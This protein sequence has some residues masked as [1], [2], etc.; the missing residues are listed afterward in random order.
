M[1]Q[2]R[3]S[4]RSV[5][6]RLTLG[7]VRWSPGQRSA[8]RSLE[9]PLLKLSHYCIST[10][11]DVLIDSH[12]VVTRGR[13]V[14]W[15]PTCVTHTTQWSWPTVNRENNPIGLTSRSV[16][17][18]RSKRNTETTIYY[19]SSGISQRILSV[20]SDV[21]IT[22]FINCRSGQRDATTER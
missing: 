15:R 13:V 16:G 7:E 12:C 8:D 20:S 10:H 1:Q 3:S 21:Y 9:L 22:R 6:S 5:K 19:S 18:A 14:D 17:P 11:Y 4:A 2:G